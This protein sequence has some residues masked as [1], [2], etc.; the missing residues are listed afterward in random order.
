MIVE[1]T[2][3]KT[4]SADCS[5][6]LNQFKRLYGGM[7]YDSAARTLGCDGRATSRYESTGKFGSTSITYNWR[8]TNG[9][10]ITA[11]FRDNSLNSMNQT[12]LR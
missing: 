2:E 5:I 10:K 11:T 8:S 3:L 12:G 6:T 1:P 7:G 9:G 4:Q